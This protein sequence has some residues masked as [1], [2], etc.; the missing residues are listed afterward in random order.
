MIAII[1]H[2]LQRK[3]FWFVFYFIADGLLFALF[4]GAFVS[5]LIAASDEALCE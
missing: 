5:Y 2:N 4:Q 3:H 1:R